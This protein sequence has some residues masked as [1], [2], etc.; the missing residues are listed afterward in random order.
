MSR[1][2]S[3]PP[4]SDFSRRP[5]SG[6][7]RGRQAVP[8]RVRSTFRVI[9]RDLVYVIG[10]PADVATEELLSRYEYFGQ[11]GPIKKIVVNHQTAYAT[12]SQRPT[13]GAYVTFHSVSDAGECL[14]ALE[15]FAFDGHAIRASFG[16][17]KYCS[18]FLSGQKC[19]NPDCMYL[20]Y[21]GDA[22]DS[23]T[24]DEIDHNSQRFLNLSRPPRPANYLAFPFQDQRATKFP[25]RRIF[26]APHAPPPPPPREPAAPEEQPALEDAPPLEDAPA[27][28]E[29]RRARADFVAAMLS[30]KGTAVEALRVDYAAGRSLVELLGLG[31]PTIRA[32][33]AA[34]A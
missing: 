7:S 19:N 25:P 13:A 26:D 18:N 31:A 34:G 23:F 11:Y 4:F 10:I 15:N 30:G 16:T 1:F 21:N 29:P 3:R 24:R 8:D 17:T 27:P 2:H 5:A 28:E 22:E 14:F 12:N 33:Y 32:A 9:Q 20:H 6:A